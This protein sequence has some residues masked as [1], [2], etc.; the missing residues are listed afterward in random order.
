MYETWFCFSPAKSN[1]EAAAANFAKGVPTYGTAEAEFNFYS[2]TNR[3]LAL[4]GVDI[5]TET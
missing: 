1:L 2:W 4:A 5:T 3:V